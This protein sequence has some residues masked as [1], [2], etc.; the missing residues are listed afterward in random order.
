[1]V[2]EQDEQIIHIEQKAEEV[3]RDMEVGH[4]EITKAIVSA[5]G[6]R[7]KRKICW[8]IGILILIGK[9]PIRCLNIRPAC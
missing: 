7:K 4:N 5:K 2:E 9:L 8:C 3:V 6:A 1:M